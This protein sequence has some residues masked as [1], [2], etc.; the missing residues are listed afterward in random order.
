MKHP[1]DLE[2]AEF[3]LLQDM[4]KK[5]TKRLEEI[6]KAC[7]ECGSFYTSTYT[8]SVIDQTRTGI[9]G[10]EEVKE[11]ISE[12]ILNKYDLI[13]TSTFQIVKIGLLPEKKISV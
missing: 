7:K 11:F 12:D 5:A 4:I 10:L 3:L 9:A 6:K 2:I 13:R 1:T 8:V